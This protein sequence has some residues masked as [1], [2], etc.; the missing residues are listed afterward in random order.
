VPE[1]LTAIPL[2]RAV[3][4]RPGEKATIVTYGASVALALEAADRMAGQDISVEVIDLQTLQ[5]WDEQAVLASLARTHRL[6]I[7]HE[8][9]EAFGV[10]AEIAARL[11][12]IGFDELDGPIVRLG[13][14]FM[15]VPFAGSL[16]LAYRPSIGQLVAAIHKTMGNE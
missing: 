3:T 1:E 9:V 12:D 16:E 4:A 14:P 6:V 7:L 5:P 11:A 8:A 15:P 10:G 2:G 13:A